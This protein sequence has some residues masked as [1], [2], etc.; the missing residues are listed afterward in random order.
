MK[1]WHITNSI[2]LFLVFITLKSFTQNSN[3]PKAYDTIIKKSGV[4][5]IGHVKGK[6]KFEVLFELPS[7]KKNE[8]INN[9]IIKEIRYANGTVEVLDSKTGK[10][11]KE[12]ITYSERNWTSVIVANEGSDLSGFREKGEIEIEYTANKINADNT[13]LERNGIILLRKK[14]ASMGGKV[15]KVTSKSITRQYREYPSIQM[16]ALVYTVE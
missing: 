2:M 13:S 12:Q 10:M 3:I 15:I 8:K 5:M 7:E 6:T 14:A 4:K 11:S 16:R 1:K 9:D